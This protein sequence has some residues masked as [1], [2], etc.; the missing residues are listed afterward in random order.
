MKKRGSM[1]RFFVLGTRQGDVI[2]YFK[3]EVVKAYLANYP[4]GCMANKESN[5]GW[6]VADNG[7]RNCTN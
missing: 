5:M 3:L 6:F 2:L 7:K 1:P 4:V